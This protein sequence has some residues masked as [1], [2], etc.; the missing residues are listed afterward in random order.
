MN[1]VFVLSTPWSLCDGT[2]DRAVS[3]QLLGATPL[4][5]RIEG[6]L[7]V[8]APADPTIS[9][10]GRH[11]GMEPQGLSFAWGDG[12]EYRIDLV[13]VGTRPDE[14]R[15]EIRADGAVRGTVELDGHLPRPGWAGAQQGG[16]PTEAR[17]DALDRFILGTIERIRMANRD[18]PT[19]QPTA[20]A[21]L[22]VAWAEDHED[23]TEP[24]RDLIVRQAEEMRTLIADLAAHPRRIL[25]R[26]RQLLPLAQPSTGAKRART[27][28]AAAAD[29]CRR[30]TRNGRYA[31]E[32]GIPRIRRLEQ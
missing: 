12:R 10:S 31:G 29:S 30:P 11:R 1:P 15:I 6:P 16:P 9:A 25:E 26:L 7:L 22:D 20:W 13:S 27:G 17:A 19:A 5:V 21:R 32:P 28:G 3:R 2:E 18:N 14:Q 23:A 24:P 4:H 8:A